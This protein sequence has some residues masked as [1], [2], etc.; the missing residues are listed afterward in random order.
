MCCGRWFIPNCSKIV[1]IR[2]LCARF[3]NLLTVKRWCDTM[4]F[5][6]EKQQHEEKWALRLIRCKTA[7]TDRY[8]NV[9]IICM[10]LNVWGVAWLSSTFKP[11]AT[12]SAHKLRHTSITIPAKLHVIYIAKYH[13]QITFPVKFTTISWNKKWTKYCLYA[14]T[15]KL[16]GKLILNAYK[17]R[18]KNDYCLANSY[19]YHFFPLKH[20]IKN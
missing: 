14:F 10:S 2:C 16:F 9:I 6:L 19:I 11:T 8:H 5:Y 15:I 4:T 20:K 17:L 13:Y 7:K 18:Y 1:F 12:V 3:M